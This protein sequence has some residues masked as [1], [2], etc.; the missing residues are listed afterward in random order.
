MRSP[1]PH[2]A[3]FITAHGFGHAVRATQVIRQLPAS[4]EVT[5]FSEVSEAFLRQEIGRPFRLIHAGFDCGT[6]HQPGRIAIDPAFT[7]AR[8]IAV[9]QENKDRAEQMLALLRQI[10]AT[11]LAA[12]APAFPLTLARRLGLPGIAVVNFTWYEIYAPLIGGLPG[13]AAA[14]AELA[15][16]YRQADLAL[17]TPLDVP[18]PVF[19][20]TRRVPLVTR[21]GRR[22]TRELHA[23]AGVPGDSRIIL[24]YAGNVQLPRELWQRISDIPNLLVLCF[25]GPPVPADLAALRRV[26]TLDFPVRDLVP[27]VDAVV[28]KAGYGITSE[29]MAAG[30]PLLFLH[31]D[32]FVESEAIARAIAAWGGGIELPLDAFRTMQLASYIEATLAMPPPSPVPA[33]G[34]AVC[35]RIL[36]EHADRAGTT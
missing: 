11:A 6:L 8:Y 7:L 28:A 22:R 17:I 36:L 32:D 18:M 2:I 10:G 34:D 35:A 31:R 29:C 20:R 15:E 23:A 30:T 24:V 33:D 19:P 5:V 13:G 25:D 9:S 14:L 3:Y 1:R 27:S 21:R 16:Q 4:A 26:S 12:D